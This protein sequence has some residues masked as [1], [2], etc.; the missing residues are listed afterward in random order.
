DILSAVHFGSES[1]HS[2][3]R[4]GPE[5]V[6]KP[7]RD[8]GKDRPAF[9]EAGPHD[10]D[11]LPLSPQNRPDHSHS[12]LSKALSAPTTLTKTSSKVS[13]PARNSASVPSVTIF[14][15]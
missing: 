7:R 4:H 15:S 13:D 3:G 1:G 5:S 6:P 14:P 9:S 10:P 12:S 11:A 8:P 2:G